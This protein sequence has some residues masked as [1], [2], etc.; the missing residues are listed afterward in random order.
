[1]P[2]REQKSN[3]NSVN[4]FDIQAI[5][6][7]TTTVGE[8]ID[9]QGFDSVTLALQSGTLTDGTFT[10]LIEDGDDSGLS[11]AAAVDDLFLTNTEADTAFV[12]A[13]DNVVKTIGY[14]G[15][16]RFLRLSI[17]SASTSSGGTIGATAIRAN[18]AQLP[19]AANT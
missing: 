16:K 14:V 13:D 1:M 3:L 11:D 5:T 17:V 9:L 8:I 15:S 6:T 10:P 18:A 19:V 2:N 7:D 12:A 4:A